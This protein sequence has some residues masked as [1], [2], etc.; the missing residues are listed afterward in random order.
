MLN[1]RLQAAQIVAAKLFAAEAALD[2]ALASAAMPRA[3]MS[4]K[5][6][7]VVGQEAIE[8][9]A[10]AQ[11]SLIEARRKLVAAHGKLEQVRVEVGLRVFALGGA[12]IKPPSASQTHEHIEAQQDEA[13]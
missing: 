8:D 6:S 2:Q 5:I 11:A 13:A 4:A 3:R 1:D 12:Y 7:A 10:D 9:A